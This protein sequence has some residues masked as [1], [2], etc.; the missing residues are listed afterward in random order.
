MS[1]PL[2][3]TE[4]IIGITQKDCDCF[5]ESLQSDP[6][7]AGWYHL[8]TSGLFLDE[9]D[10]IESM[11][12]TD[13]SL[14]CDQTLAD[15]Y[16]KARKT[17]IVKTQDEVLKQINDRFTKQ[18]RSFIGSLGAKAF[19]KGVDISED[20]FYGMYFRMRPIVD[21][22]MIVNSLDTMFEETATFD[23]LI[24]RRYVRSNMYELVDT[25]EGVESTAN[26]YVKNALTEPMTLPM[27]DTTDGELEYYFVY[28]HTGLT[29]KNN[30]PTCGG[31]GRVESKASNYVTKYGVHGTDTTD[32][33][34]WERTAVNAYGISLQVE[35]RCDADSLIC[36]MFETLNEWKQQFA[37][38]VLLKAGIIVHN[39]IIR[40][41]EVSRAQMIDRDG[42]IAQMGVWEADYYNRVTWLAQNVNPNVNDC[43]MC[44]NKKLK[45]SPILL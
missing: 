10:G 45:V 2:P 3:C 9:L 25:I 15:F 24:Y 29:P 34:N 11:W 31:C 42:V 6:V 20:S 5:T 16:A 30:M 33:A 36:R 35:F 17:S 32:L 22:V 1:T 27:Y 23:V 12:S 4:N 7:I 26:R 41:P 28:D 38:S 8:S 14:V 18:D 13:E 40:S 21:G 44:D 39:E 19:T 37:Y 43:Y